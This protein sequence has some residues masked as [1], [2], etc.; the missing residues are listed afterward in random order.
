MKSNTESPKPDAE[1]LSV[2]E[3]MSEISDAIRESHRKRDLKLIS[4]KTA[5]LTN[6]VSKSTYSGFNL[7]SA[8]RGINLSGQQSALTMPTND[9]KDE[10]SISAENKDDN[11]NTCSANSLQVKEIF[12]NESESNPATNHAQDPLL[13]THQTP[14]RQ[15]QMQQMF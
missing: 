9:L 8:K 13:V 7:Q 14:D 6:S 4:K 15:L 11:S 1:D 12:S 3:L 5:S 10:Q 2:S